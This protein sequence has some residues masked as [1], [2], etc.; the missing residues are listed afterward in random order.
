MKKY[1][2][3]FKVGLFVILCLIGL[4]YLTYST[5]KMNVKKPG[6]N[7]YVVFN[8]VAGLEKKAPVMLNGLE[9]GKVEE[10]KTSYDNDKTQV[11]LKLWLE[12]NAKV[13]ENPAVSIK[14]L[15][16]MGEKFIQISSS[17]GKDFIKPDTVLQ[18]K[19]F[20]DLDVLMEQAQSISKEISQQVNKLVASL[21][22][23]LEDNK[24]NI[25]QIIKNLE[26]TSKNFEE[27]SSDIKRHPWKLLFRTKE[28]PKPKE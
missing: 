26:Y 16:L 15:G 5:G 23:T 10:I 22:T 8:D 19:P 1:T 11:I 17:Q 2:N 13:R 28:K 27:F 24:G 9:V 21:N 7:L 14:T 3:E 6:Y 18:G 25:N 12:K 4:I 20:L